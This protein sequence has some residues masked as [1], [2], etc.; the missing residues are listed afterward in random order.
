MAN[1][2]FIPTTSNKSGPTLLTMDDVPQSVRDEVE[3][4]YTVLK[5]NPGR[6]RAAFD[7]LAEM[8]TYIAQVKAYCDL[9]PAGAIR[10]RKSPTKGLKPTEM[11]FRITDLQTENE[12]TVADINDAVDAVKDAAKA[13]AVKATPAK[14]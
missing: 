9:R 14:K 10:F 5:A 13:P 2:Q 11:E 12:K 1:L 6:M 3:E 4:V 8:N 7:T